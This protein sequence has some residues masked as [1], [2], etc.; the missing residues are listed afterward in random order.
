MS[1]SCP[2]YLYKKRCKTYFFHVHKNTYKWIELVAKNIYYQFSARVSLFCLAHYWF[3]TSRVLACPGS[4]YFI[5]LH[6]FCG[7]S[8]FCLIVQHIPYY[9]WLNIETI[10]HMYERVCVCVTNM[11]ILYQKYGNS[12]QNKNVYVDHIVIKI[13]F[14]NSKSIFSLMEHYQARVKWSMYV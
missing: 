1:G 13:N 5:P 12:C 2:L 3:G 6:D 10:S 8:F 9:N 7:G 4:T 11:Y 14:L